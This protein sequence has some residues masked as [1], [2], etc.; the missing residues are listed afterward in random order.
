MSKD[1]LEIGVSLIIK[2]FNLEEKALPSNISSID[3]LVAKL[4]IIIEY[5]LDKDFE[6]LLL[7]FYRIDLSEN[8]VNKILH[9]E[10]PGKIAHSLAVK[11]VERELLKA[12]F[13]LNYKS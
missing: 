5:M 4:S 10:K 11:V 9:E 13:R 7:A 12:E 8:D 3:E 6:R 1:S 2:D